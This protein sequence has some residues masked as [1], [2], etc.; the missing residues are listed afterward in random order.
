MN[1]NRA[2]AG[3]LNRPDRKSSQ[4]A[5]LFLAS[6][7]ASAFLTACAWSPRPAKITPYD[8]ALTGNNVN[9]LPAFFGRYTIVDGSLGP[10]VEFLDIT[11]N[12]Y[13]KPVFAFVNDQGV[14]VWKVSPQECTVEKGRASL[15]GSIRCGKNQILQVLPYVT[16]SSAARAVGRNPG[17]YIGISNAGIVP[18]RQN[19]Y[20]FGVKW[21]YP[22]RGSDAVLEKIN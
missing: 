19:W 18:F 13:G 11:P 22:Q 9:N 10:G 7:A 1:H 14:A 15:N 4:V 3:L 5:R 6:V 17:E 8:T 21:T 12:E 2:V 16:L 20:S